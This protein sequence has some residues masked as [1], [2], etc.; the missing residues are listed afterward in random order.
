MQI[1]K[2]ILSKQKK[3]VIILYGATLL[4]L[5]VGVLNSVI[6]TNFL[7]PDQ[8]GDVRYV[9]N[10]IAFV[11]SI[12]LF[13]YFT[14]GSRLLALSKNE[15]YSQRIRGAMCFILG[16]S[17][18]LLMFIM[19]IL[20]FV[21]ISK[22]ESNMIPIYLVAIPLCGNV[23]MLNYVNTTAQGD[24]HIGRLSA[25]R[26]VPS[27]VYCILAYLIFTY[28]SCTPVI[29]LA[30]Y[31]GSA[32]LILGVIIF[33]T[34][35]SFRG[36]K[37]SLH[38]LNEENKTYGWNIYWGS[39][40]GV[41]TSYIAGI[42]LG[43]FSDNNANVGFYTL[44]LTISTPLNTLPAIIGTTYFKQFATYK[45][46]PV[47]VWRAS[48]SLTLLSLF[49]YIIFIKYIVE[50]LFDESYSSVSIYASYLAIGMSFHGLGDMINRFLGAHGQGSQIRNAAFSCG[51]IILL[52][53][54]ILVY[55]WGI[56]GAIFTKA[57]SSIVYFS[58]LFVYYLSFCKRK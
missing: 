20:Y 52:G 4:G 37:K 26:L 36:L 44:A 17:I 8:Y 18:I 42:T 19:T 5:L 54:T 9:Q 12:L 55:Y 2:M 35:P 14:S 11:S 43:Q 41:S 6:N 22:G 28:F 7:P 45:S 25:A 34:K 47:K 30:L 3:Q 50:L 57:C 29:M 31:N 23:V 16:L 38:F 1:N 46:I 33:S 24:N 40:F 53:S 21:S 48:V 51:T 27:L 58:V 56:N 10:I 39:I 13:G 32:L 15:Q 49:C